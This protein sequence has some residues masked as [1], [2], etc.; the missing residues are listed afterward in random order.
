MADRYLLGVDNVLGAQERERGLGVGG[1][2]HQYVPEGGHIGILAV[3][4]TIGK[5]L[6]QQRE[7][8]PELLL[9]RQRP[10]VESLAAESVVDLVE[11]HA[12]HF[13]E[14]SP[15]QAVEVAL[16]ALQESRGGQMDT[17]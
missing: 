15:S 5:T 3:G 13:L 7:R 2:D 8:R 6:L 17:F 9:S 11:P 1:I 12:H 16:E 10:W 4:H 14:L